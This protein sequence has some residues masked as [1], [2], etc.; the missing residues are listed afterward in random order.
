MDQIVPLL[1]IKAPGRRDQGEKVLVVEQAGAEGANEDFLEV[2][3][4]F[5]DLLI[6]AANNR[7][8]AAMMASLQ[9]QLRV[10]QFY[11]IHFQGMTDVSIAQHQAILAALRRRDG[12]AAEQAMAHHIQDV[13]ARV[14]VEFVGPEDGAGRET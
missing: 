7:R 12:A 4:A 11:G 10:F 1:G 6:Q 5:H 8:L 9:A 3:R 13:K 14:L 2:D